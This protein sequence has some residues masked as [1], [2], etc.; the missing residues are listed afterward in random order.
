ML[1]RVVGRKSSA[2]SYNTGSYSS[3]KGYIFG[4]IEKIAKGYFRKRLEYNI[5]TNDIKKGCEIVSQ[6]THLPS[7]NNLI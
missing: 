5:K 4:L 6:K 1:G 7:V 2:T 3:N